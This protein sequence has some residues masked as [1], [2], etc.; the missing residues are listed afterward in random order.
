MRRSM[1]D[2]A[3]DILRRWPWPVALLA[4]AV[5]VVTALVSPIQL[6]SGIRPADA[7]AVLLA[8]AMSLPVGVARRRPALA[9]LVA[10][11]AAFGHAALHYPSTLG[12]GVALGLGV[13]AAARTDRR[14]TVALLVVG[15]VGMLVTIATYV[16]GEGYRPGATDV[17]LNLV[18]TLLP[19]VLADLL[20][21]QRAQAH[22]IERLRDADV[23]EAALRARNE[24]AREVH[25]VVGHHLSAISVQAGAGRLSLDR[26]P[27]AA[28]DALATIAGLSTQAL[29]ETR[30]ALGHE[31]SPRAPQPRLADLDALLDAARASGVDVRL[32]ADGWRGALPAAVE[33]S[34]F[35]I[36][37]EALTN[38]A[39][40]ATPARARVCLEVGESALRVLVQDEGRAARLGRHGQGI[41]GMR[42]RA[43]LHG[44]ALRAGP[45]TGGGGWEVEATLP[46][47][48]GAP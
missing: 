22:E 34:A 42:E 38:V 45:R 32:H 18:V 3:A 12:Y 41:V 35:R 8:V 9:G 10:F 26:D 47:P 28:R 39:R 2:R 5:S 48:V 16:I 15:V 43:A 29:D 11:A 21:V 19:L 36:V 46:L 24:V 33:A 13:W 23:R 7:I 17:V 25:D 20:R 27:E 31:R 1:V 40:H 6:G 30:A 44:G 37:Q 4:V 14:T